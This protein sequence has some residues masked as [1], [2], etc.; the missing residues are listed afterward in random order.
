MVPNDDV[1]DDGFVCWRRDRH[2]Y[3]RPTWMPSWNGGCATD[4]RLVEE[5][6]DM[7][8][9]ETKL[10]IGGLMRCC[11]KTL[12]DWMD[13]HKDDDVADGTKIKCRWCKNG[14][15]VLEGG[16]WMWDK[17]PEPKSD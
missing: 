5:V 9:E 7:K 17:Q 4:D 13:A 6:R 3:V 16:I 14:Q 1:V 2:A 8:L 10:N 11:I 15:M 12:E